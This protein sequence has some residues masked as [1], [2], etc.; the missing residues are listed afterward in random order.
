MSSTTSLKLSEE[1][2]HRTVIAARDEGLSPH[3][4]MVKAIDQAAKNV[5]LRT[6]FY[7]DAHIAR[8][9]LLENDNGYH[10]DDVHK[11]L[12]EKIAG[13]H[14]KKPEAKSWQK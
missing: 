2:K 1:L 9:D 13:K 6:K 5:E 3:A 12:R 7:A 10:V 4:F 8:K 14:K 11:Y